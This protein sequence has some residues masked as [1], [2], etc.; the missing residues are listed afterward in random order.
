MRA[1]EQCTLRQCCSHVQ[2]SLRAP[3]IVSAADYADAA[4]KEPLWTLSSKVAIS[5][6]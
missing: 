4:E 2:E 3:L 6:L 5:Q 1:L